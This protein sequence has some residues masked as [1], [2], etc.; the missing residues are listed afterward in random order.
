MGSFAL[1]Q[2]TLIPPI[3]EVNALSA[4]VISKA[5]AH[6]TDRTTFATCISRRFYFFERSTL[7]ASQEMPQCR[8]TCGTT[9]LA[10]TSELF[11]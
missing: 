9:S 11:L 6:P 7:C 10:S 1:E 8:S 4:V 2:A 5:H 3:V